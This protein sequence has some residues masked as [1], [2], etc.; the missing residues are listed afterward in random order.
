MCTNKCVVITFC[1]SSSLTLYV[2]SVSSYPVADIRWSQFAV[3][4]GGGSG[5]FRQVCNGIFLLST[6]YF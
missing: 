1:C 2:S 6:K 3:G 5:E 4:T